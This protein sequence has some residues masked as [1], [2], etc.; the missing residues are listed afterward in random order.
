MIDS[1]L[2]V[3]NKKGST[4]GTGFVVDRTDDVITIATCAHVAEN[5]GD[6]IIV[7]GREA[8]LMRT[9]REN[10]LDLALLEVSGID[11]FPL[12]ITPSD[13]DL[14][15]VKVIGYSKLLT[16]A[17]KEAILVDLVKPNIQIEKSATDSIQ[18]IKLISKEEI[19]KGYSGSPVICERRNQVVAVVN[20]KEG[21]NANYAIC[22]GHLITLLGKSNLNPAPKPAA[23]SR[24]TISSSLSTEQVAVISAQMKSELDSSLKSFNSQKTQW[25]EPFISNEPEEKSGRRG[26]S[27]IGTSTNEI[28][29]SPYSMIINARH[30]YGASSLAHYLKKLAWEQPK[31]AYWLY[32]DAN[33]LSP[34]RAKIEKYAARLLSNIG[35]KLS[36]VGA[37]ILDEFSSSLKNANKLVSEIYKTFD[38]L[39]V[40]IMN[41]VDDNPLLS[42]QIDWDP[43]APQR[44]LW[45]LDRSGVRRLVNAYN[46]DGCFEEENRVLNK[47]VSDLDALN[48]PR[49]P[50]N[51]LTL[52]KISEHEFDDSPVNRTDMIGRVLHLLFN[53][54]DIPNYKIRPDLKDTE[55][56]LG[57]FCEKIILTKNVY[58]T[59]KSFIQDLDEF[60]RQKEIE[61]DVQVIFDVLFMN[62]IIVERESGFCFKFTYW[63]Y[64]FAAQRMFKNRDFSKQILTG[65]NYVNFPELIEFYTGID[66]N[67][68]DALMC[69]YE[70]LEQLKNVVDSKCQMPED[71][72]IYDSVKWLPSTDQLKHIKE[73][74]SDCVE[75]SNLPDQVKDEYADRSYDR[76]RPLQ[77][78]IHSIMEQYS[79]TRLMKGISAASVALR[80]S[81]YVDTD[82]KHKI[83][84]L[85]M[86]CWSIVT[87]VLVALSPILVKENRAKIEGTTFSL[88]GDFNEDPL[89]KFNELLTVIPD[90]ILSWYVDL[91]FSKRMG[92]LLKSRIKQENSK[93]VNHYLNLIL[94]CKRPN[95]WEAIIEKYIRDE[96]KNSFYLLSLFKAMKSEY[97]YSFASQKEISSLSRLIKTTIAK[98]DYGVKKP[99]Q[100]HIN[101]VPDDILPERQ[102]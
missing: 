91:L 19:G 32:L 99:S 21:T 3:T 60:C 34:N 6:D 28:I 49:S 27:P 37:V 51:C 10:G 101:R 62:N 20:I 48:I 85:I 12:P 53:V 56:T 42:E 102:I 96:N 97:Q 59:R 44:Y 52:L 82:L 71:F 46:S 26:E 88:C 39:P 5:C 87:K 43:N 16:D 14:E 63:V 77:Q 2:Y 11:A 70:D 45:A 92:P 78:N 47:I 57:Y 35:L 84:N 30:Q 75:K 25:V 83:L 76:T 15:N 98:H 72:N 55:Y 94:V 81:D 23:P 68:D 93:I 95:D 38:K 61:L 33:K 24:V 100:K 7:G 41:S 65:F 31:R 8:K 73:E 74:V 89:Q 80:N 86:E 64:Y 36:D 13:N 18:S 58:F 9:G 29:E 22:A 90:N 50:Q 1:V 4:L 17:K 40:I 69:I 66:R 79:L 67:R 54:D